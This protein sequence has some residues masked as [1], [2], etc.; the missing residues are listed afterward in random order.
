M[1]TNKLIVLII[2]VLCSVMTNAVAQVSLGTEFKVNN[3]IVS[4]QR[5][6]VVGTD[7]LGYS[8]VVWESLG[9]DGSDY[10]IYGQR[11]DN[12]G[13]P[14]GAEFLVNSTTANAQRF[15]DVAVNKSGDKVIVWQSLEFP[16]LN[17]VYFRRYNNAGT[18]L[19]S[20]MLT[21]TNTTGNQRNPKV[22]MADNGD[23]VV[24]WM[25]ENQDGDNYGIYAQRFTAVGT[26]VGAEFL[27]NDVIAGY[28]GYPNVAM[29]GSGAFV[30]TWQSNGTDGSGN[31]IYARRYNAAGVALGS[32]FLVN[33]TTTGNQQEPSVA[34][35]ANGEFAIVWSSYNQDGS[36]YGV[37][38]QLYDAAGAV[39]KAEFLIN[40]STSGNQL[41]PEIN[42]SPSGRYFITW[43]SDLLD[44]S[45]GGVRMTALG[46]GGGK[47]FADL[48]INNRV[49]DYQ[50]FSAVASANDSNLILV[51]QDGL[52]ASLATHDGDGYGIYSRIVSLN[53]IP[54]PVRLLD[55]SVQKLSTSD[56][57]KW[58]TAS[59][60]NSS[61]FNV[62]RSPDG[63]NF[64]RL[65]RVNTQAPN[66]NSMQ[67]L[68]YSY[69][70]EQPLIGHNYYRLQQ[71]DQDNSISYSNIIDIIW[72]D[73][74]VVKLYPNPTN[75]YVNIDFSL[76]EHSRT[77]IK[78][79]DLSGRVVKSLLSVGEK[80]MNHAN[81]S[82]GELAHGVYHIQL[83]QNGQIVYN[84]KV[85]KY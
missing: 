59:E 5:N 75:D 69:V 6:P 49:S 67:P 61:H 7:S 77:E 82:M 36:E 2:L 19:G 21:N 11:L 32:Q 22:A 52:E 44:A 28:Q 50:Q 84:S 15:P 23:F 71:V 45:N 31:G 81:I 83:L 65:G 35:K 73:G 85:R 57:V 58:T 8:L 46:L 34:I 68:Y 24:V 74:Q 56:L 27:V 40:D 60:V 16:S 3:T 53:N 37:Y 54:L 43:T 12:V 14:L 51:Y 29:Q 72:R 70:D 47:S 26:A 79:I 62:Q 13:L 25:S 1:K 64:E 41:H 20:Q 33:S 10:G 18:A 48:Q 80:G 38:A 4:H 9:N 78:L 66:G 30:I 42:A 39:S 76:A 63:I 17:N 55:F